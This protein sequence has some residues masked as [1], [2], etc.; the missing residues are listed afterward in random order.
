M[1]GYR[2][3]NPKVLM[4]PRISLLEIFQKIL[5]SRKAGA[6]SGMFHVPLYSLIQGWIVG[7]S[8]FRMPLGIWR[9]IKFHRAFSAFL[10]VLRMTDSWT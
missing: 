4:C 10:F 7:Q 6:S 1:V 8:M 9:A 5:I 3:P 2:I